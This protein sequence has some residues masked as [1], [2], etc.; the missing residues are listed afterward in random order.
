G[1]SNGLTAP[2]GPA[3]QRVIRQAL[4]TAGLAPHDV[5]LVEGHGTGTTLGD[6]IEAQALQEVYGSGRPEDAPLWLGSLKSNIGHTAAAAGVAGL[7]KAVQSIRHGVLPQSLHAGT[8]TP[9]VEWAGGG[10]R[11]LDE[12]RPWPDTGRPRRAG[13]S[14]FGVSGTNAHVIVEEAPAVP[15]PAVPDPAV[16][17]PAIPDPAGNGPGA[18][19]PGTDSPGTDGSEPGEDTWP[20]TTGV[21]PWLLSAR[22]AQALREQAARLA[23]LLEA[24]PGLD[25]LDVSWSL[26]T[27]RTAH[28]HR[29]TVVAGDRDELLAGLR[30]LADQRS[31]AV[32]VGAGED[33]PRTARTGRTA[34]LFTGQGSQRAAMGRELHERFPA[35]ARAFDEVAAALD[36]HCEGH[37]GHPVREAVLSAA[38]GGLLDRTE[39]AQP[40]LFAVEVALFRLL[41]TWG[42]RPDLVAGHSIGGL[43]AA[44]VAG[45]LS[46]D[47]AAALVAAR[48]RLMQALPSGGAMAAVEASEAEVAEAL[49]GLGE[50]A[51]IAAV[52]GPRSVVVSGD[53]EPVLAVAAAFKARGRRTSRLRVGHAFHSPR[54]DP[55]LDE[56]HRTAKALR[57]EEPAVPVISD[58]TGAPVTAGELGTADHWTEHARR[59]VRFLDV[60]RELRASGATRFVEIGP[61]AV[62]TG[63]AADILTA[64][65]PDAAPPAV[66]VPLLRGGRSEAAT[67]L[68]ALARLHADGVPVDW[69]AVYEGRA[70]R[71]V[72]LPTYPF[73]RSRH[74]LDATV[75]RATTGAPLLSDPDLP[76]AGPSWAERHAELSGPALDTAL[77]DLVT[78]E[79][80][81]VLGHTSAAA[82][83][84]DRAFVEVGLDSLSAVEL[85]TRLAARTGLTLAGALT[86][87]Y[88]EPASLARHL[89]EL[90][91]A[92]HRTNASAEGPLTTLYL[93][94]CAAQEITAATEVAVAASRLR[95]TFGAAERTRHAAE[96]VVLAQ[97]DARTALVCFPALTALSGPHEYAR[98]GRSLHGVRDVFAVPAPGYPEDSALPDSAG[99]FVEMQADAVQ[100]LM[101][102]RPFAVLGRSLGGCVAHAV[103][104]ELE[105]RGTPP[106]GLAMV[107]TYPMDT[108]GLPGMEWWMPA[109]INGMVDRF[110][111]FDLG[112]TDNGIT[113]MGSYLRTFGTW[114]PQA[115]ATPT[116]LLRAEAP[117]PGTPDDPAGDTR[118]F[119]RLPHDTTDVPGD[120]FSVL[121][122]HSATTA[123]AVEAWLSAL[124]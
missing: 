16:L 6:P 20:R 112:L 33:L 65:D 109:M 49:A 26:A 48:G 81:V 51:A 76:V 106:T 36:R 18:D 11:L 115:V 61:D 44:H 119:W 7:I 9:H 116:L 4:A 75:T 78:A 104:A 23:A 82:V 103:T 77:L 39:Y 69:R 102:E 74:W 28:P 122:E 58:L 68:T 45:V 38:R 120:H 110:D 29:A 19:S 113:T 73:Q 83:E 94:L 47:D 84:P 97:G 21:L 5:D 88:P 64:Q 91:Q 43:A 3:Q 67:L 37:L 32:V 85:R 52:N 89:G 2:N 50:S 105:R 121:E 12:A 1:A 60:V 62:L 13:V 24:R 10:V 93:R 41:D 96:P 66:L 118:A 70:P 40:A 27:A 107:D 111:A 8:P 79:V 108:A 72:D 90:M 15:D 34:F 46:L 17:D 30:A 92:R 31:S 57:Y 25:P 98:F 99:A 42:V 35:Y 124:R 95:S 123:A 101:G 100:R 59:P 14:A 53:E 71:T 56:F 22:S 80:S 86:I 117:L 55:M 54:M 114:Q 63:L 87:R